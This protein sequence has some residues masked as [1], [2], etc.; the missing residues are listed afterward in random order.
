MS[1]T[2]Y[3]GYVRIVGRG[4]EM[5]PNLLSRGEMKRENATPSSVAVAVAA[6]DAAAA[7]DLAARLERTRRGG[8]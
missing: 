2:T 8:S 7:K 1:C 3:T 4:C 5:V 6:A